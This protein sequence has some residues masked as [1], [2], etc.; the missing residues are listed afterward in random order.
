MLTG[1]LEKPKKYRIMQTMAFIKFV[2]TKAKD[3][4]YKGFSLTYMPYG[5]SITLINKHLIEIKKKNLI[6]K[7]PS[8]TEAPDETTPT[9]SETDPESLTI[10]L[11]LHDA[12][13]TLATW[14]LFK[15]LLAT[16]V[17]QYVGFNQLHL[18]IAK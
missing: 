12:N 5:T 7:T 3:Q 15:S 11:V 17:N 4:R 16:S 13:K 14:T 8:T 2:S 18:E 1:L 10:V 9:G 6:V